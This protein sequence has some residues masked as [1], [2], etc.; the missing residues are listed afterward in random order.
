MGAVLGMHDLCFKDFPKQCEGC[1]EY[2]VRYPS[3]L[4]PLSM[5]TG[6]GIVYSERLRNVVIKECKLFHRRKVEPIE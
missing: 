1:S 4:L 5:L 2:R 3:S 6:K